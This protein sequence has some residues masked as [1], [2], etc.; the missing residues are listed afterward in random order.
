MGGK[1][2]GKERGMKRGRKMKEKENTF[3]N[4]INSIIFGTKYIEKLKLIRQWRGILATIS[5]FK[6]ILGYVCLVFY[7]GD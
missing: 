3:P 1:R 7:L 6:R 5:A 2:G 4:N